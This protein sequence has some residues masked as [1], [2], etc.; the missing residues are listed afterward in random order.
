MTDG[1]GTMAYEYNS[2]SQLTA[3]TRDF[4]DTLADAPNSGLF[5][6]SYEYT[7]SGSLKSYTDPYGKEIEYAHQ[8]NGRLDGVTGT[9]FGGITNYMNTYEFRAWGAVKHMEY[10]SGREAN[11]TYNTRQQPSH[12]LL[13][14]MSDPS[15]KTYDREYEYYAD[16]RLKL[17][18][19]LHMRWLNA[20][21]YD[22]LFTYDHQ[23]RVKD[24]KS[25]I[26]AHGQT[27]T[28][29]LY[30]PYR[31][32]YT[33]NALGNL[34]SRSSKLWN[35]GNWNFNYTFS[36]NRAAFH[37]YDDDGRETLAGI[38]GSSFSFDAAGSM[39]KTWKAQNYETFRHTDG[40]NLEAKRVQRVWD[41]S[42][43]EWGSWETV[44]LL[45]SSVLKYFVTE[46]TS[47]GKKKFTYVLGDGTVIARQAV[48]SDNDEHVGWK[49][50]DASG[51]SS[52][53]SSIIQG[54]G[55]FT[56]EEFD[57][58]GNNVGWRGNFVP[59]DRHF[60]SGSPNQGITFDDISMGDCALDGIIVPCSM[61]ERTSEA[62]LPSSIAHYQFMRGFSYEDQG[63]GIYI[64]RI[65]AHLDRYNDRVIP[66]STQWFIFEFD[67]DYNTEN[68]GDAMGLLQNDHCRLMAQMLQV[69]VDASVKDFGGKEQLT[70]HSKLDNVVERI[71]AVFTPF[72]LGVAGLTARNLGLENTSGGVPGPRPPFA[73]AVGFKDK[74]QDTYNPGQ[75][76]THH[77]AAYFSAGI[78]AQ[79]VKALAHALATDTFNIGDLSLGSAAFQLGASLNS[80]QVKTG[81]MNRNNPRFPIPETTAEPVAGRLNRI[82]GVA[83][84]VRDTICK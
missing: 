78:N 3:E 74:Y 9:S 23:G 26:E 55:S 54:D 18:D 21:V 69:V 61:A 52:R 8:K 76:Q 14:S 38:G 72:Y 71:D 65:P 83:D 79:D 45:Y 48:E 17:V 22:R 73:G 2:L 35:Y 77:F 82:L 62:T 37:G 20:D 58:L 13:N 15:E 46:A 81:R 75:E 39:H 36:N 32:N 12:L 31:Q 63:L 27:E 7:L 50:T 6:L 16:G 19:E 53:S 34:T 41:D 24:A 66:P 49:H 59:P 57:G 68:G 51:M 60:N 80:Q 29:L 28:D 43:E 1:M 42:E 44:Y 56:S 70:D 5:T 4:I 47:S 25:G 64:A 30:L 33:Y 10:G 67:E 11:L 84:S 40:N